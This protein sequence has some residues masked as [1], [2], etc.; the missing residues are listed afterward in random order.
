MQSSAQPFPPILTS[1]RLAGGADAEQRIAA[2]AS[3][4]NVSGYT[5]SGLMLLMQ[6]N[7]KTKT[8]YTTPIKH[9]LFLI[10]FDDDLLRLDIYPICVEINFVI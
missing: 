2:T 5:A 9:H 7:E 6:E 1:G 8:P 4:L 10:A 3:S